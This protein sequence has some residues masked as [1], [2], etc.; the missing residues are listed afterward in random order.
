MIGIIKPMLPAR[1]KAARPLLMKP[2]QSH[3]YGVIK[4]YAIGGP[5]R[6]TSAILECVRRRP[7]TGFR[8]Q[9]P[10]GSLKLA[11][12]HWTKP[13][14]SPINFLIPNHPSPI[15]PIFQTA[16]AMSIFKCNICGR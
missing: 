2:M 14:T 10:F 5:I 12:L 16:N 3:G 4:I 13:Q 6:T 1:H 8:C 11:V 7:L 9:N 15:F